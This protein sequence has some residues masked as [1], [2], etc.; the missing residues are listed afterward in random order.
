MHET[1]HEENKAYYDAVLKLIHSLT[2][3]KPRIET[4]VIDDE[5]DGITAVKIW[6]E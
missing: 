3:R 4:V 1:A 6:Y 5:G 2:G